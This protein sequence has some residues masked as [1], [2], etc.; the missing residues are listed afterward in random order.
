[1][2]EVLSVSGWLDAHARFF[3]TEMDRANA[4]F[5]EVRVERMELWI[6]GVTPQPFGLRTTMLQR[7][8]QGAWH[9]A[10]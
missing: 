4:G 5:I 8:P 2:N 10:T 7:D 9:L 6:K 1:M 3:P